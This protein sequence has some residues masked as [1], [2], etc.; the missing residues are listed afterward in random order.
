MTTAS[1]PATAQTRT[2]PNASV[3]IQFAL[4]GLVWGSSF[5]FIAVALTGISP[6]QVAWSRLALGAIALGLVVALRRERLPRSPRVWG[7]MTVL[8]VTFCV[9]PYLLF[10]WAQQHVTSGLA[11]IYNATTPIMTAIMAGLVLRAEKLKPVQIAGIVIGMLGVAVI[12][13]PWQG[14]DFS[15]SLVAQ[16]AILGATACYGFSLAYMR[17]FAS[18]TGMSA[19]MFSFLNIGIG[20]VVMTLLAPVIALQPVRLDPWVVA[21]VVLLGFFGTGFAYIWNQ[22]TVR[23]WGPTRASTVTYITPVVGVA[24]GAVV[25]GEQLGW[26]EPM[27]ALVV[28][29]G[30]LLAQ[31]RLRLRRRRDPAGRVGAA[32]PPDTIR[33][34]EGRPA[35]R[36]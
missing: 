10:S 18:N 27:G 5:L 14:L 11:S 12:I 2:T 13:A 28:F 22:N 36:G 21:S 31:N 17:R 32:A 15:Q 30:I 19:A 26:N 33:T 23:A 4:A 34:A 29:L 3:A 20:A 1:T 9:V 6:T 24:L 16:F 25:L 7:H 8:A 35:G